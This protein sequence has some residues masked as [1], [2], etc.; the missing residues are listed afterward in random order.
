MYNKYILNLIIF[1]SLSAQQV[2]IDN[3]RPIVNI[4]LGTCNDVWGYTD[5]NGHDFALVGHRSGTYVY[6]VSTNPHNPIEVG[7]IAGE[8]STWR[9]LKTHGYYCYVTN[10]TGGGIDIISLEDPFNPYKVGSHTSSS[11]T[12]HNLFIADGYA[13]VVG[14]GGGN[15]GTSPWQ[16]IIILDLYDPENPSEVGR[17]EE[18]YI[19]DVY[20]KNDTA[21]ACD[22]YNGSL[23]MIDVS[24]KSN[25]STM[26]EHNYDN[27]GCHAVWITEDSK[28][29]VTGD[30]EAGGYVYIFDIQDFDN[31]NLIATWYPDEPEVQNKSVHNVLIK[32]SLLYVSYYVYGTRIVDISDPYNPME[33]GYYDW[34]P[35]QNGLYNGNWGTYPFTSNGLIY[36]TDYTGNGFFI[37]SYPFMGEI[38]FEKISDTENNI[39]PISLNVTIDESPDYSVDYSSLKLYW[40]VDGIITDSTALASSGGSYVGSLIPSGENGIM[41][42]YVAFNTQASERVTKPY[43]APFSSYKFNIGVDNV[44]PE[45]ELITDIEDQFYPSGSSNIYINASDNI[46]ISMVELFWQAGNSEI[47]STVCSEIYSPNLGLVYA[48]LI[49]YND[50]NPGTEIRYWAVATDASS[51][52]N[53]SQSDEKYFYIS[54]QY[55][56]GNFEDESSMVAWDLGDWGRQYVNHT[57]KWAINDSPNGLYSPNAYNACY[58]IEPINLTYFNKAYI[59][60]NSGE[61]LMPGDYG[62]VQVKRGNNPSWTNILTVSSWNNQEMFERYINLNSY[63]N[64]DELYLRLLMTSDLSVESQ[65][66]YVDDI[67]LIL[68]QDMPPNV[69]TDAYINNIPNQLTLKPSY[70]NPFNP[71][72]KISF[73]LPKSSKVKLQIVD[74]NGRGIANLLN[75]SLDSGTHNIS[76]DGTNDSGVKMS[77]GIYFIILNVDRNILSQKLSLIR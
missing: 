63:M 69:T 21:Y 14:S 4:D 58:L 64:E 65:G 13:Y 41:H 30:E 43:G 3:I 7:F 50:I 34:Y 37:M 56:L 20:V 73:N 47:E 77:S 25:P 61:L 39:D 70:P 66:W 33:V 5:P 26:V 52:S 6:D 16:G 9:D 48:G 18:A 22:I 62:Y 75:N 1:V 59:K 42:Y 67:N 32:D 57:I 40:G 38:E 8:T 53:Q 60:F 29:A 49:S 55:A 23:F 74:I 35:G 54:D 27:Y 71:N 45:V 2:D 12:A 46:E 44:S 28:Y 36:S 31:I 51:Q 17:W 15:A 68:N 10:E 11:T 24:D 76:W 72:T 19:H